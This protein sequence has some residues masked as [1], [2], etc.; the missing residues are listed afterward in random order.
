MLTCNKN[1]NEDSFTHCPIMNSC[2]FLWKQELNSVS[3]AEGRL[4]KIL[5]W[6]VLR[7]GFPAQHKDLLGNYRNCEKRTPW[8]QQD[9]CVDCVC[10]DVL[11]SE[12]CLLVRSLWAT[13]RSSHWNIFSSVLATGIFSPEDSSLYT[14]WN[15]LGSMLIYDMNILCHHGF[16]SS[17]FRS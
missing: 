8:G 6:Q 14:Q 1:N 3:H 16:I 11:G 17:F 13:A 9:W 15:I 2:P 4:W 7:Q 5:S 12:A 10:G